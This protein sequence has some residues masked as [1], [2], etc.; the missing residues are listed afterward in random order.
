M[1]TGIWPQPQN[2]Y[3]KFVLDS[4]QSKSR[5]DEEE[6]GAA[7][8]SDSKKLKQ[9]PPETGSSTQSS[10]DLTRAAL[11]LAA[12][13]LLTSPATTVPLITA[14][15]TAAALWKASGAT[16]GEVR[17]PVP[18]SPETGAKP[19]S[20]PS[21]ETGAS[22]TK[23]NK[24]RDN[25]KRDSREVAGHLLDG[26][27][28]AL[29]QGTD[30]SI[31]GNAYVEH[32]VGDKTYLAHRSNLYGEGDLRYGM[33]E[34][35]SDGSLGEYKA[36]DDKAK[37]A[38]DRRHA[39]ITEDVRKHG[40]ID[41]YKEAE[42]LRRD[43]AELDD[44]P[45]LKR[46]RDQL[47]QLSVGT[48]VDGKDIDAKTLREI[49]NGTLDQKG[50]EKL[51]Q[52]YITA[53]LADIAGKDGLD[54]RGI[55]LKAMD[56]STRTKDAIAEID[57]AIDA[58]R[59]TKQKTLTGQETTDLEANKKKFTENHTK[60]QQ[61]DLT[62]VQDLALR[63]KI[64][65]LQEASTSLS[66]SFK[67]HPGSKLK[68]QLG[69]SRYLND[70]IEK[71]L[72]TP[73]L[74]TTAAGP[75]PAE[76]SPS[77]AST[78]GDQ[79]LQQLETIGR[80]IPGSRSGIAGTALSDQEIKT[81]GDFLDK[82]AKEIGIKEPQNLSLYHVDKDKKEVYL[83]ELGG[84]TKY[85]NLGEYKLK[86]DTKGDIES[87]SRKTADGKWKAFSKPG[88]V[89]EEPKPEDLGVK[90]PEA[91]KPKTPESKP[92]D[93]DYT[94]DKDH[95]GLF[96][97]QGDEKK[98]Y[99][100][101]PDGS[102][103]EAKIEQKNTRV[104]LQGSYGEYS[105][106]AI[107]AKTYVNIGKGSE[108]PS[109]I[110]TKTETID[111]T[112]YKLFYDQGNKLVGTETTDIN[113]PSLNPKLVGDV[114]KN[115]Q[116]EL[117]GPEGEF[118]TLVTR[119]DGFTN[120][121]RVDGQSR[122]FDYVHNEGDKTYY[123]E[124]TDKGPSLVGMKA[125]TKDFSLPSKENV[126]SVADKFVTQDSLTKSN[127]KAIDETKINNEILQA[128]LKRSPEAAKLPEGKVYTTEHGT[129]LNHKGELLYS[130]TGENL[131]YSKEEDKVWS[132]TKSNLEEYQKS[133]LSLR[134]FES[135]EFL[136]KQGL[137]WNEQVYTATSPNNPDFI[138]IPYNRDKRN[139]D[140]RTIAGSFD[141]LVQDKGDG[142]LADDRFQYVDVTGAKREFGR[143]PDGT[144]APLEIKDK[145]F[146]IGYIGDNLPQLRT[147]DGG[148]D[149]PE[150]DYEITSQ[151]YKYSYDKD[152]K[153]LSVSGT[154]SEGSFNTPINLPEA[155]HIETLR[156][157]TE[158]EFGAIDKNQNVPIRSLRD[159][160]YGSIQEQ[161]NIDNLNLEELAKI[162]EAIRVHQYNMNSDTKGR[163][164]GYN[165]GLDMLSPL[166]VKVDGTKDSESKEQ[167]KKD[168]R[169]YETFVRVSAERDH[170]IQAVYFA[171]KDL[172]RRA[173]ELT[174]P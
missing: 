34:I 65:S 60:L 54:I 130:K 39:E 36:V 51:K 172:V 165:N 15:T 8:E 111:R 68:Y 26:Q 147:K 113:N 118:R 133:L 41:N 160:S 110:K 21:P 108:D 170:S 56:P 117:R 72:R 144:I 114:N 99:G 116:T 22:G 128:A 96:R 79:L 75:R 106:D 92:E 164:Y 64:E 5:K 166:Y 47:D 101:L 4:L 105:G 25:S 73:N 119:R 46:I 135:R 173:E 31:R 112:E 125:P 169:E 131:Y 78:K 80:K 146:T 66:K 142:S 162:R 94:A 84:S 11:G 2:E 157:K 90:K 48:K 89:E 44:N 86:I 120:W 77:A 167:W 9:Q 12:T 7:R 53:R 123:Y 156:Q 140:T 74:P 155:K 1:T 6:S 43:I 137:D 63:T 10:S 50:N 132:Y 49:F 88:A 87:T 91:E 153:L 100:K 40:G 14:A 32:K 93:K 42:K 69:E 52:E 129:F 134:N 45:A 174:Q 95:T 28:D 85:E 23:D 17:E 76:S 163:S 148:V 27:L 81:H 126:P 98:L 97:K 127:H 59:D 57:K 20:T 122:G 152:N 13:K 121:G 150:V 149:R 158:E 141:D 159:Q 71:L 102:F 70:Q 3:E 37:T 29:R 139:P 151:G 67:D 124:N 58:H 35:R 154:L 82:A 38:L 171:Y 145:N 61:I 18:R 143:M 107:L 62:R 115:G 103:A 24:E 104:P 109:V 55:A 30:G 19:P 138:S 16:T 33:R 136:D 161:I 83:A 168:F